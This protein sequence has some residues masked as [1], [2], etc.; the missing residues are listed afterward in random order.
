MIQSEHILEKSDL[1]V[2]RK[3]KRTFDRPVD[4]KLILRLGLGLALGHDLLAL[5]EQD[6]TFQV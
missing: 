6:E 4:L 1:N 2:Q 5:K 3:L